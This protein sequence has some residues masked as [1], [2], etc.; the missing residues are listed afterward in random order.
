VNHYF[1]SEA[2]ILCEDGSTMDANLYAMAS[3]GHLDELDRGS[4]TPSANSLERYLTQPTT[5]DPIPTAAIESALQADRPLNMPPVDAR[6]EMPTQSALSKKPCF[7]CQYRNIHCSRDTPVCTD[8]QVMGSLCLYKLP[9]SWGPLNSLTK[10]PIRPP[11]PRQQSPMRTFS[12]AGSES[13]NGSLTSVG[14]FGSHISADSRGSRRGRRRWAVTPRGDSPAILPESSGAALSFGDEAAPDSARYPIFCTWPDCDKSFRYRSEWE[15]HE[16]ACHYCPYHWVC[17]LEVGNVMRIPRC[18][19]CSE[20]DVLLSHLAECHF[21]KCAS[22]TLAQRTFLRGDQFAAH[23]KRH[24]SKCLETI[25]KV[26]GHFTPRRPSGPH[27]RSIDQ[28]WKIDNPDLSSKSLNCGFCGHLSK[29][30]KQR[31]AH[32]FT[33]LDKRICKQ[34]WWPSRLPRPLLLK[35]R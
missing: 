34:A 20:Q 30:W 6:S 32:V 21:Q 26:K 9:A 31:Q 7:N 23:L 24:F 19:L 1:F 12:T 27:L 29:T 35:S 25:P 17:C 33:H 3:P 16:E 18:F 8:C 28:A 10:R 22:Q 4:P 14:S 15:R 5:Q 2:N 13:S 11:K